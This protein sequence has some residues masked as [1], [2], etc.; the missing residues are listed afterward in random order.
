MKPIII[1]EVKRVFLFSLLLVSLVFSVRLWT[2]VHLEEA[3]ADFIIDSCP[4][5]SSH[6]EEW[7]NVIAVVECLGNFTEPRRMYADSVGV[8]S[9]NSELALSP[10]LT[11]LAY[12]GGACGYA[13][14]V[15]V[16]VFERL[17]YQARF[18]QVLDGNGRTN[19]V[20]MDVELN[21]GK[22]AVIDPIFGFVFQTEEGAPL[23]YDQL[24]E[25]WD[26]IVSG[27][28]DNKIRRYSYEAGVR[29]TNWDRNALMQV[30]YAVLTR[31]NVSPD[32]MSLRVLYNR[33]RT[34]IPSFLGIGSL[35]GLLM[36]SLQKRLHSTT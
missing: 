34:K 3:V 13:T 12:G 7:Q 10:I 21:S 14:E 17:G 6:Q 30:G 36:M 31:L 33:M 2:V 1:Y 5:A 25:Q 20:V 27:L 26:A 19:H 8:T 18:V 4:G 15:G 28:P 24:Q 35:V 9:T 22:K 29:F 16:Q 32:E 23:Q 11:S